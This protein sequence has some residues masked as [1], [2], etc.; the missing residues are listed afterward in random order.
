MFK[1]RYKSAAFDLS[2]S[3]F[4]TQKVFRYAVATAANG[5]KDCDLD[6]IG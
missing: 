6:K 5:I 4:L 2:L 3:S 1:I